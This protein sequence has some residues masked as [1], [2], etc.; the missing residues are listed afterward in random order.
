MAVLFADYATQHIFKVATLFVGCAFF[1][2]DPPR[3]LA[4][5][6]A[7]ARSVRSSPTQAL[8]APLNPPPLSRAY[9][10]YSAPVSQQPPSPSPPPAPAAS[11]SDGTHAEWSFDE[12]DRDGL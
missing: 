5:Q 6:S 8:L 1:F 9:A 2:L 10:S 12:S 4:V 3:I 7:V 11:H